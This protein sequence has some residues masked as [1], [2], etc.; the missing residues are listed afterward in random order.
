M[1][2]KAWNCKGEMPYC[3][4]RSSI[5]FQGHPGQNITDF[6]PNCAFPDYW[7]VA[8]FKSLR[9]A[10]FFLECMEGM[11]WKEEQ[12]H[13]PNAAWSSVWFVT[14]SK[15]QRGTVS[16]LM[17]CGFCCSVCYQSIWFVLITTKA[18]HS[19]EN[20]TMT[21][22]E[23]DGISNHQYLSCFVQQLDHTKKRENTTLMVIK[24]ERN[25]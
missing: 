9:F 22:H 8:A 7:P 5:K 11:A 10:L 21:S 16:S 3:F 12:R 18:L 19:P 4:R 13:V 24:C 6:D 14:G 20:I 2:H 17:L 15:A 23:H 25:P 1:L